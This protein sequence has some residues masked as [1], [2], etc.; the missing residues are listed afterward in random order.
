TISRKP[1]RGPESF[2]FWTCSPLE[3]WRHGQPDRRRLGLPLV[4]VVVQS[5]PDVWTAGRR[6]AWR[7]SLSLERPPHR[8][9]SWAAEEDA[10]SG[11]GWVIRE[12]WLSRPSRVATAP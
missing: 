1:C 9:C 5:S 2:L 4:S 7:R 11:V 6:G 3:P 12:V 10:R 8:R